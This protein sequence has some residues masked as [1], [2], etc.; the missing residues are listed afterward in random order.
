MPLFTESTAFRIIESVAIVLAQ[1]YQLAR[2]RVAACA[3]SVL[4][5]RPKYSSDQRLGI[6]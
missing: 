2:A 6:L 4:H 5:R 1:A 3:S